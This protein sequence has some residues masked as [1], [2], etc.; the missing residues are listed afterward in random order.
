MT[1]V[2]VGLLTHA[3]ASR[4]HFIGAIMHVNKWDRPAK[5]LISGT[6]KRAFPNAVKRCHQLAAPVENAIL[7]A[8]PKSGEEDGPTSVPDLTRTTPWHGLN[9]I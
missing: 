7:P 3:C 9:D 6:A 8:P 5:Q 1:Y 2:L 4:E